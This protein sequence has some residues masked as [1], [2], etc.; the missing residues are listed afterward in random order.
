[1]ELRIKYALS[2]T[3]IPLEDVKVLLRGKGTQRRVKCVKRALFVFSYS[4]V[5]IADSVTSSYIWSKSFDY[6][7]FLQFL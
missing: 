6:K 1:M 3:K 2:V 5:A 7:V 4:H